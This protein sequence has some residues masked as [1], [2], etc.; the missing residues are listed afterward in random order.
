MSVDAHQHFWSIAR[1]DYGWLQPDDAVLY[2]DLLP[3]DL[4]PL[5]D[6]AGIRQTVLVQAAP[7]VA[8]T[9]FLLEI[10]ERM[11]FVAGVVGWVDL[12][13]DAV[14]ETLDALAEHPS[15]L[16]V[17]PMIQDLEDD[18][19]M[20]REPV[21]RGVRAVA[22]RG[23]RFDAL[24]LPKHLGALARFVERHPELPIV[25]DHA[26][27]PPIESGAL[28]RWARELEA[29]AA[30]ADVHCKLSGL[31]TEAG[32][33]WDV[34]RLRPVVDRLFELFGAERLLWGSDWPVVELAGGFA[35]WRD[36]THELL[37]GRSDAERRAILGENARRFYG[38]PDPD[39][40]LEHEEDPG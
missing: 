21:A 23:L 10:A 32:A 26:A 7:T 39:P 17:R 8:E 16:G 12:E 34:A 25:V 36:A 29:V 14:G 1:D 2:R 4:A 30:R 6:G 27:K 15:L 18:A 28:D 3:E 13:D 37:R 5:L 22:E 24:V 31:V 9:R 19:W 35:A 38:L 11:P 20:L 40:D 33:D